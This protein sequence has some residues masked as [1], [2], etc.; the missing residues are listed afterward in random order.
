MTLTIHN[1]LKDNYFKRLLAG[2]LV[3]LFLSIAMSLLFQIATDG[4]CHTRAIFM[5]AGSVL[6]WLPVGAVLYTC[7]VKKRSVAP[8][9]FIP[10]CLAI[11]AFNQFFV[12]LFVEV[13]M[14]IC[15]GCPVFEKGWL[16][17]LISNNLLTN[18]ICYAV[19]I[20]FSKKSL[21]DW[22]I[23][24]KHESELPDSETP[25]PPVKSFPDKI[26]VKDGAQLF[27]IA[28]QSILWV[29]VEHNCIV[30]VTHDKKYVAYQSLKSFYTLLNPAVFKKIHRSRIVNMD[31][32]VSIKNL[33]SSDALLQMTNGEEFRVSRIFKKHLRP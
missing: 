26:S 15:Y 25:A 14:N 16:T 29:E 4:I 10:G 17:Y 6:F 32:V 7:A 20:G 22:F 3:L 30:I 8:W 28:P 24:A 23:A 5:L 27:W 19:F 13:S 12:K 18:T 9:V 2:V 33:P 11:L 21:V 31:F 1:F